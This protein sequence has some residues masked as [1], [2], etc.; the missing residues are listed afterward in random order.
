[1]RADVVRAINEITN[2]HGLSETKGGIVI[3]KMQPV[4]A[5][6]ET[7]VVVADAVAACAMLD[8]MVVVQHDPATGRKIEAK[9]PHFGQMLAKL[10]EEWPEPD[11]VQAAKIALV[12]EVARHQEAIYTLGPAIVKAQDAAAVEG[13]P[14]APGDGPHLPEV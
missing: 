9:V 10:K 11:A 1:M 7:I 5:T 8:R 12:E 3:P 2:G 13:L 4:A 6:G 14:E